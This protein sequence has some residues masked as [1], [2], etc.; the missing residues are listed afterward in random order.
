MS[1]VDPYSSFSTFLEMTAK[2]C[3][4]DLQVAKQILTNCLQ[5]LTFAIFMAISTIA[6]PIVWDL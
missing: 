5:I 3:L 6:T 4:A 2:Y 1:A